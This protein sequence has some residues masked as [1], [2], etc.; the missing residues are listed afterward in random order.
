MKKKRINTL[1]KAIT[2]GRV[3]GYHR[4]IGLEMSVVRMARHKFIK[5]EDSNLHKGC[6]TV[7]CIG[8]FCELLWPPEG[9]DRYLSPIKNTA[10]SLGISIDQ[11]DALCCPPLH[12]FPGLYTTE[13]AINALKSLRDT[14]KVKWPKKEHKSDF[15]E[16]KTDNETVLIRVTEEVENPFIK[17]EP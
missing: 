17:K 3:E 16:I 12:S 2:A 11:S 1:I 10:K 5:G 13:D 14:G 4:N 8:G 6:G 15:V 7:A 9:L